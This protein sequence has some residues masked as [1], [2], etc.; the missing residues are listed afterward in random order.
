MQA[1]GRRYLD[2]GSRLRTLFVKIDPLLQRRH[3][4][5][6]IKSTRWHTVWEHQIKSRC[7]VAALAV[8]FLFEGGHLCERG[9]EPSV[10]AA[11]LLSQIIELALHLFFAFR[12][13]FGFDI[14]L[15]LPFP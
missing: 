13:G 12:I 3:Y 2:G 8:G 5:F 6:R 11:A 10:F 15:E 7:G 1:C 4:I 9:S 14:A